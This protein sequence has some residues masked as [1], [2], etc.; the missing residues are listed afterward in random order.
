MMS[1][2]I[3][4]EQTK[5]NRVCDFQT[6]DAAFQIIYSSKTSKINSLPVSFY[7]GKCQRSHA[8]YILY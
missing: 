6:L 5:S 7:C 8:V 1:H 4:H 3:P 2:L